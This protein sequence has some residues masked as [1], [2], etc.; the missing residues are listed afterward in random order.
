M[1]VLWLIKNRFTQLRPSPR[2]AHVAEDLVRVF[3][4]LAY[5]NVGG[6]IIAEDWYRYAVETY[7][8]LKGIGRGR[9]EICRRV[10]ALEWFAKMNQNQTVVNFAVGWY[11]SPKDSDT[12]QRHGQHWLTLLDQDPDSGVLTVN[13]PMPRTFPGTAAQNPQHLR[14]TPF[15][16][17][18]NPALPREDFLQI[19]TVRAHSHGRRAGILETGYA[20][21]IHE[22][23][24]P[25]AAGYTPDACELETLRYIN[26]EFAD[27]EVIAPL[28]GRGGILKWGRGKLILA[29]T[30]TTTGTNEIY[31]GPLVSIHASETPFGTG[32]IKL[33]GGGGLVLSP[34][35]G[36]GAGVT[37][38][39][40]G[41]PQ[42]G[43]AFGG[44]NSVEFDR[45]GHA[46]LTVT[47]GG[48]TDGNTANLT[49]SHRGTLR[50]IPGSGVES[51]GHDERLLVAGEGRNLPPVTNGM[52]APY[53]VAQDRDGSG[54]FLRYT[55]RDGFVS[56]TMSS[57]STMP[58]DDST[59]DT[60]YH[61]E[62]DQ[63]IAA[64]REAKAYAMCL[65][66]HR[67][68]RVAGDAAL[69]I[70]NDRR[71]PVAGVI[72]NGGTI[73]GGTLSFE[74]RE[75]LIYSG[76]RGPAAARITSDISGCRGITFFGP[77]EIRLDGANW[78]RG[79]TEIHSGWVVVENTTGTGLGSDDVLVRT[80][81][82]LVIHAGARVAGKVSLE[83][84][85][86]LI[87]KG[88]AIGGSRH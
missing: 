1:S 11:G 17:R 29:N 43:V 31:E 58:I 22:S 23:A 66:P 46:S 4:G 5:A 67:V 15:E 45:N 61:V 44:G 2:S 37:S 81:G 69:R 88:G 49:R 72:L 77:G 64:G 30:N 82:T 70:G 63:T 76:Q 86:H 83:R 53:V 26:G 73:A 3:D 34:R 75:G 40:A 50:V 51:L 25:S 62:S 33:F 59:D 48:W 47:L 9:L 19:A 84:G 74:D 12:F 32:T 60:I 78:Y 27:L 80:G 7:L 52:V 39:V 38:R 16:G 35:N 21:T 8:A 41:A 10:P 6:Q 65:D 14:A 13:N 36:A 42:G 18:T 20:W 54:A 71:S 57:S 79:G 85:S 56:A 55:K 28:E 24:L 87:L 68:V